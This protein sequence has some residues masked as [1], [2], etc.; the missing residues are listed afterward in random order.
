MTDSPMARLGTGDSTTRGK[1]IAG[2]RRDMVQ[3][4]VE[5]DEKAAARRTTRS[6]GGAPA[7]LSGTEALVLQNPTRALAALVLDAG[8]T[9]AEAKKML[10]L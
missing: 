6:R 7:P 3:F 1:F 4:M 2:R 5:A 9:T 8:I 10:G